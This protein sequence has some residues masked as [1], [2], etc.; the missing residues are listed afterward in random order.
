MQHV[1]VS[2]LLLLLKSQLENDGISAGLKGDFCPTPPPLFHRRFKH[3]QRTKINKAM[4]S[5][6]RSSVFAAKFTIS[7]LKS[8][9]ILHPNGNWT[10]TASVGALN[11]VSKFYA[12]TD[13][14]HKFHKTETENWL[15]I[16][17]SLELIITTLCSTTNGENLKILYT[18]P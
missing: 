5:T 10:R 15:P 2:C 12:P 14:E 13:S 11:W 3:H 7:V 17:F 18:H 1:N 6:S 16:G 9:Y 8:K 4:L